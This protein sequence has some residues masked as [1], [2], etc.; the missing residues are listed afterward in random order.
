MSPMQDGKLGNSVGW[1][2]FAGLPC[3]LSAQRLQGLGWSLQLFCWVGPV[4]TTS[5]ITVS[6]WWKGRGWEAAAET[7]SDLFRAIIPAGAGRQ[8]AGG[9]STCSSQEPQPPVAPCWVWF[10]VWVQVQVQIQV[11]VQPLAPLP[12][13]T[14]NPSWGIARYQGSICSVCPARVGLKSYILLVLM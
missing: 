11:W 6:I 1:L 8:D 13:T 7:L 9:P 12:V 5:P 4:C 3:Q 2:A 14:T 10:W